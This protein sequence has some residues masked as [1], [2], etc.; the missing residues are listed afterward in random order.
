VVGAGSSFLLEEVTGSTVTPGPACAGAVLTDNGGNDSVL[1]GGG[2]YTF[3]GAFSPN[4]WAGVGGNALVTA[5]SLGVFLW[6]AGY[7]LSNGALA[8]NFT[9]TAWAVDASAS[10]VLYYASGATLSANRF[11]STGVGASAWG[12][13]ILPG[14]SISDLVMDKSG[15][16][17]VASG[18]QVSA[19]ATDSPGLGTGS[20]G[21]PV[22]ARDACRSSNLE[23]ACPY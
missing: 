4:N 2:R 1:C 11:T 7:N 14:T 21:W 8:F 20:Y 5:P 19:I 23:F 6:S 3:T 16:L 18:G 15:N 9:G 17:Y 13:P 22:R 12:L 10:P